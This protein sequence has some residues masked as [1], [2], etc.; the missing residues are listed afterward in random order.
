MKYQKFYAFFI[1]SFERGDF[2]LDMQGKNSNL[3]LDVARNIVN[4]ITEQFVMDESHS[5]E[6]KNGL[7]HS[8]KIIDMWLK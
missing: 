2:K 7:K 8:I 5:L 3:I 6:F 4:E 1:G